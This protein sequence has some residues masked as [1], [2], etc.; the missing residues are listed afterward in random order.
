MATKKANI[1]AAHRAAHESLQET[2]SSY[3]DHLNQLHLQELEIRQKKA[4]TRLAAINEL[5]T[6]KG[7][8]LTS[9]AL[10]QRV[11]LCW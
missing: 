9:E 3:H 4:I 8:N 5:A 7:L 2:L 11:I 10:A 6:L 1:S